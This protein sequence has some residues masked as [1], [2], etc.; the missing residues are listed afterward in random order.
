MAVEIRAVNHRYLEFS[1]RAPDEIRALE[2]ALREALSGQLARGKVECRVALGESR[3]GREVA[4]P[5]MAALEALASQ[6]QVVK[7]LFPHADGLTVHQVLTWAGVLPMSA[8]DPAEL[9]PNVIAAF[10]AALVELRAAR[11]REGAK[12]AHFIRERL[13]HIAAH[14]AQARPLVPAA[15]QAFEAKLRDRIADAGGSTDERIANEIVMFAAR[16]DVEEEL[17]RL[18]AHV[19][20][21]RA[22]LTKGG[23][24]G[25][26]L[27]FLMQE[28]NRE[29][30]TLGSKSVATELTRIAVDLKVW[31][32][33]MRE[34]VQNIE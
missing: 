31:I 19:D 27:D 25:K 11:E 16:S 12:L 4:T 33:Q 15:V 30:N 26:R 21:V 20:E 29:A 9:G 3:G 13:D 23:N 8:I 7:S 2:P 32:E 22:I 17:S 1:L 5:D 24:V 18:S 10:Q 34:Q 6:E 14:V 28:L